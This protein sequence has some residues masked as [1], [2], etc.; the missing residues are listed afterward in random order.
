MSSVFTV[1]FRRKA[2]RVV[3]IEQCSRAMGQHTANLS[4]ENQRKILTTG[5]F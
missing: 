2:A 5:K 4:A 1:F 3:P